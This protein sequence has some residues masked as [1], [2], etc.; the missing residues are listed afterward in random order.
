M[1]ID[2][3]STKQNE[4][5]VVWNLRVHYWEDIC[6]KPI[7]NFLSLQIKYSLSLEINFHIV[8]IINAN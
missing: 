2:E 5:I 4:E 1:P 8:S 6:F 7:M 3:I